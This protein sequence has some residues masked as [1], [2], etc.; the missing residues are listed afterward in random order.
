MWCDCFTK[1]FLSLGKGGLQLTWAK[2]GP[3]RVQTTPAF[4]L[5]L[6]SVLWTG[7]NKKNR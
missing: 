2:P 3:S 5:E 7:P 6:F 1:D 4:V